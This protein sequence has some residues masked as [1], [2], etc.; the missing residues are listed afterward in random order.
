MLYLF[1]FGR[2]GSTLVEYNIYLKITFVKSRASYANVN[3]LRT[4][5]A[6]KKVKVS[7]HIYI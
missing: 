7:N 4:V 1:I 3:N 6:M 5:E 2:D